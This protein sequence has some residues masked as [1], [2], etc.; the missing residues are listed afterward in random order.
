MRFSPYVGL[1]MRRGSL[2]DVSNPLRA[3]NNC[4]PCGNVPSVPVRPSSCVRPR[5]RRQ[6][7]GHAR[8]A[9]F[10]TAEMGSCPDAQS[11]SHANS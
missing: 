6:R 9:L 1:G 2:L 7:L 3:P 10:P 5:C 4:T 8:R 11:G